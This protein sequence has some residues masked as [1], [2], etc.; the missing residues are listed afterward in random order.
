[1]W[2]DNP[3]YPV[4]ACCGKLLDWET[5]GREVVFYKGELARVCYDCKRAIKIKENS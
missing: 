1:M 4:C 3:E 2:E 5:T